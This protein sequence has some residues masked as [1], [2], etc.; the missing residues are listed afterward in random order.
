MWTSILSETGLIVS[1]GLVDGRF[2]LLTL[3]RRPLRPQRSG[4]RKTWL[5][6]ESRRLQTPGVDSLMSLQPGR[7]TSRKMG[8]RVAVTRL[9]Q[10]L[11]GLSGPAF[12]ITPTTSPAAF[13]I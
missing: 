6:T 2:S 10:V 7:G 3:R 13:L 1:L 11:Q 5:S 9:I 8:C 12:W 4:H